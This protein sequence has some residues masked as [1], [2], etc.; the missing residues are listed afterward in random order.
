[1]LLRD[2]VSFCR[3]PKTNDDSGVLIRSVPPWFKIWFLA[4]DALSNFG[5]RASDFHWARQP[6]RGQKSA[7][8]GQC[9]LVLGF[10]ARI[11][12]DPGPSGKPSVARPANRGANQN[13]HLA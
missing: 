7:R 9:L 2:N 13:A 8:F 4:L 11:G 3:R 6:E 12:D 10:R 5:R 1:M